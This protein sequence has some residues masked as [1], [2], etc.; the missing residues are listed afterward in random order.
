MRRN[1]G[2]CFSKLINNSVRMSRYGEKLPICAPC[3]HDGGGSIVIFRIY[4]DF[5]VGA[6]DGDREESMDDTTGVLVRTH[7]GLCLGW[8]NC[9]RFAPDI[10]PLDTEG[11]VDIE[12]LAVP[13]ENARDAWLGAA[14]CPEG[15]ITVRLSDR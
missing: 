14:A 1:D 2:H 11:K 3:V 10:Y 12:R 15:A 4:Y 13:A 5:V 8:G 7:P 9:H 6:A